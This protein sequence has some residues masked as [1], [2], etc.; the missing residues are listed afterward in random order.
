MKFL[1]KENNSYKNIKKSYK[2]IIPIIKEVELPDVK[3]SN[4]DEQIGTKSFLLRKIE[5]TSKGE[6]ISATKVASYSQCPLKYK[7][8]YKYGYTDLYNDFRSF[9]N[10]KYYKNNIY[11]DTGKEDIRNGDE[12]ESPIIKNASSIKGQIIHKALQKEISNDNLEKYVYDEFVAAYPNI[13]ESLQIKGN[14]IKN[15]LD[16]LSGFYQSG[17]FKYLSKFSNYNNETEIY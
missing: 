10:E 8:I 2:T 5:D 12:V 4:T 6:I 16:M 7:F 15:I 17:E 13:F 9:R 3:E 11:D 14:F 1:I